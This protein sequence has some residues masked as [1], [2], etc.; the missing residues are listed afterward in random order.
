MG[1]DPPSPLISLSVRSGRTTAG[2][3][4]SLRAGMTAAVRIDTGSERSLRSVAQGL[5]GGGA[6]S[7]D[8]AER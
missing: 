8:P 5:F 1:H 6:A 2:T 4:P 3:R 7:A